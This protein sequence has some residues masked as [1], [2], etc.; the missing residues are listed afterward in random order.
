M[1]KVNLGERFRVRVVI[2]HKYDRC[3]SQRRDE[4]VVQ[5]SSKAFVV[6]AS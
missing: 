4:G 5:S 6:K 1:G 3:K 2:V